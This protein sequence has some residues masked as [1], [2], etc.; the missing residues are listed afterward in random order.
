[1]RDGPGKI[2]WDNRP[3]VSVTKKK[4]PM[5]HGCSITEFNLEF[6]AAD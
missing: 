1:V 6:G 3:K 2:I 5:L 4:A